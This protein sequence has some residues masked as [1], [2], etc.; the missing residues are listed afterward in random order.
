MAVISKAVAT[1]VLGAALATVALSGHSVSA[2][3]E[4]ESS[5]PEHQSRIDDPIS[6]VTINFGSAV[7]GVEIVLIDPDDNDLPSE[8]T[9]VSPTEARLSFAEIE[10][11]GEYIVRYLAE[12]DGHLLIG[13]ITF[14][15]GDEAGQSSTTWLV[16]VFVALLILGI[17][18]LLSLRLARR[19]A[20]TVGEPTDTGDGAS[21]DISAGAPT[22]ATTDA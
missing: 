19:N 14:V 10:Q 11:Q 17:G 8:V 4:I 16:F 5:V 2:H 20:E 3:D 21:G 15:Y 22:D 13:A 18:V 12:E 6:Q 1:L 9:R 7:G